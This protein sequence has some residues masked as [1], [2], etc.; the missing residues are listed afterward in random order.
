MGLIKVNRNWEGRI[1]IEAALQIDFISSS[2][3]PAD[4]ILKELVCYLNVKFYFCVNQH[5]K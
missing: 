2:Q 3:K 1:K 4:F 5:Y